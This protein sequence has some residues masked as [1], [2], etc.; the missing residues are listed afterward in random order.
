[1]VEGVHQDVVLCLEHQHEGEGSRDA[2]RHTVRERTLTQWVDQEHCGSS[3][4]GSAVS[5][6]D[7]R[8]HTQTVAQL[9]LTTHVA[10]YTDQEVEDYQLVRTTVVEPLV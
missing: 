7:P 9:P 1:M 2:Q 10:E 4:N 8:T 5:N 3:S 6:A